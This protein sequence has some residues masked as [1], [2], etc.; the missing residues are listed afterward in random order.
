LKQALEALDPATPVLFVSDPT[1]GDQF[2][3]GSAGANHPIPDTAEGH[4]HTTA[5]DLL[6]RLDF[7]TYEG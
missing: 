4:E 5:G 1:G 6:A 2:I 3:V 7:G